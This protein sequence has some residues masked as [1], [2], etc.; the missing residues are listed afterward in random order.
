M[1]VVLLEGI[2]RLLHG[3]PEIACLA[4]GRETGLEVGDIA[5]RLYD[6][7]GEGTIITLQTAGF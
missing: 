2:Q 6:P 3:P 5:R 1:V 7:R 4:R